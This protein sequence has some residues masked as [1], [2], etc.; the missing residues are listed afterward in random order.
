[1]KPKK[2]AITGASGQVGSTL[3]RHLHN[4]GWPVVAAVRNRLGAALCHAAVPDCDI[5]VGSLAPK[6][7]EAHLL[8]DCDVIVNCALESGVG[9]PRQAYTR[10]RAVV[11]GL[12]QAKSLRWLIHFSTVAVYGELIKP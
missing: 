8:D 10:N 5:R 11:D 1:M 12:L 7:G 2:V 3:L 4:S 6:R 9:I